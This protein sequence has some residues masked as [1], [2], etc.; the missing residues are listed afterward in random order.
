MIK[1][2]NLYCD[3][4]EKKVLVAKMVRVWIPLKMG[5]RTQGEI[6]NWDI[7]EECNLEM[8]NWKR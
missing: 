5:T 2:G 7:C 8:H 4:C 3:R 1:N 6:K